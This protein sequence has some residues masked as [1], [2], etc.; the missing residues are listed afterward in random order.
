MCVL[1]GGGEGRTELLIIAANCPLD[2]IIVWVWAHA[3]EKHT[4]MVPAHAGKG[5]VQSHDYAQRLV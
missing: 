3:V 2:I 4:T 5:P 1:G